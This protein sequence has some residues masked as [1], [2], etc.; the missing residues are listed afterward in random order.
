[1]SLTPRA[2]QLVQNGPKATREASPHGFDE[3]PSSP[4]VCRCHLIEAH[5][6]HDPAR[7]A[8]H[9]AAIQAQQDEH[10]RRLGERED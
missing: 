3:D 1:M 8:E 9:K 7:V 4:G 6:I 2:V 10:L 5:R